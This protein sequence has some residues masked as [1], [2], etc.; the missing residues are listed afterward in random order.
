MKLALDIFGCT[1][2][3]L[4]TAYLYQKIFGQA[5][6]GKKALMMMYAT[7]LVMRLL[8][9]GNITSPILRLFCAVDIFVPVIAYKSNLGFKLIIAF[10]N[11]VINALSE[12]FA[13]ALSLSYYGDAATLQ[14]NFLIDYAYGVTFSRVITFIFVLIA[15]SCIKVKSDHVPLRIFAP[16]LLMPAISTYSVYSLKEAYYRLNT[17]SDYL[18]LLLN[19]SLMLAGNLLLFYLFNKTTENGEL[20]KK[21]AVGDTLL[22]SQR[23]HYKH[24][25]VQ[26]QEIRSKFHDLKHQI[27]ALTGI[28]SIAEVRQQLGNIGAGLEINMREITGCGPLDAVIT[29]KIE[30]ADKQNTKITMDIDMPHDTNIDKIDLAVIIAN[31]LDNALEA[32]VKIADVNKRWID[33]KI[34]PEGN[35]LSLVVSNASGG[36]IDVSGHIKTSKANIAD[37]GYGI[38]NI[39]K[40]AAQYN[41]TVNIQSDDDKFI[42][43]VTLG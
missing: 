12:L 1:L 10:I 35:K 30:M 38:S 27:V 3:T 32:N 43:A 24:L 16:L 19:I 21:V 2:M 29:S 22:N 23:L 13:K 25:A 40:I 15:I 34:R 42:I 17:S 11:Y 9:I 33:L 14:A 18:T 41:G 6:I 26:Q 4:T 7:L 8:V 28:D 37:H 31:C 20:K 5:K 36:K 39:K